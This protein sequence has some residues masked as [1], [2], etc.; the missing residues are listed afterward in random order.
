[1]PP[2][3]L[4][5]PALFLLVLGTSF[6]SGVFGMAG[7]LILMGVL[8]LLLPVR[9]AMLLHGV[10]QLASNG[11]RAAVWW[12]WI[13]WRVLPPYF[14]GAAAALGLFAW[15]RYEP[16]KAWV[17]LLLGAV[18]F[19]TFV[20]PARFTFDIER[21]AAAA[22]CG[23]VV[24]AIQIACG[25]SGPL[26]D[27]FF[28][29]AR[30]DRRAVIATKAATQS[31]G[32]TVKLLY[33]GALVDM[34]GGFDALPLWLYAVSVAAA[35]AGGSLA[36]GLLERLTDV[37]FRQWSQ[38]LLLAVGTVYLVQG[39]WTLARPAAPPAAPGETPTAAADERR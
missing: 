21:P 35:M 1:M 4:L 36:R 15:V 38:R 9:T 7:G 29:R 16:E 24:S 6:L 39:G 12:R 20:L 31:I 33:F 11:W 3:A 34:A 14:A 23:F 18:P 22:F 10:T 2:L 13:A 28:V 17:L 5:A 25:V 37:Q 19:V 30:M 32:H 8:T 27:L 26:L